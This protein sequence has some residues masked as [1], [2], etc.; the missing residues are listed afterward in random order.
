MKENEQ[1]VSRI[2]ERILEFIEHKEFSRREFCKLIAI[3]PSHLGSHN[4]KSEFAGDVLSKILLTFP[5]INSDWLLLGVGPM[6]KSEKP[7]DT[8]ISNEIIDSIFRE[9]YYNV[10]EKYY[11]LNEEYRHLMSITQHKT[12]EDTFNTKE[13]IE[14]SDERIKRMELFSEFMRSKSN[15]EAHS[16]RRSTPLDADV[17]E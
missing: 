16:K 17:K 10:L 15:G 3:N 11:T 2:K 4:L 5:E 13:H 8:N 12:E 14:L 7:K 9:K 6:I 1:K